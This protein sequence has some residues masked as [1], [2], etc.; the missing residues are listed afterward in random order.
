MC[1]DI[2]KTFFVQFQEFLGTVLF[3]ERVMNR[4][5]F[6]V[7]LL[8]FC[9]SITMN[10]FL[11]G[12]IVHY[13]LFVLQAGDFVLSHAW[14]PT[15]LQPPCILDSLANFSQMQNRQEVQFLGSTDFLPLSWR[16]NSNIQEMYNLFSNRGCEWVQCH[17]A[18]RRFPG[19]L[20][21]DLFEIS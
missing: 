3:S 15:N 6:S 13:T 7:F 9:F 19:I 12:I 14:W 18:T 16:Q 1:W 4:I 20:T 17:F 11:P 2:E 21:V 5:H 10:S 8:S